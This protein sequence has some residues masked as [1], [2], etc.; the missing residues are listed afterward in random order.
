MSN[1]VHISVRDRNTADF[2]ESILN[3]APERHVDPVFI[4]DFDPFIP[5]LK[6]R[7]PYLLV[8]AYPN[9]I[10]DENE[11]AAIKAYA[12]KNRLDILCVGMQQ[13]WCKHNIP[14]TAF[15][16]LS[17]V[18]GAQCI[19]TDTF[20]GTVFS[21][22]YNKRFVAFI[23]E[24]N[25]NKLGGLLDQLQLKSRAVEEI[26]EFERIMDSSIDYEKV[27]SIIEHERQKASGYLDMI[28][29]PEG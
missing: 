24:S 21:A 28:T 27:N 25:R 29:Q 2:V 14:A 17:Y 26:E 13:R 16:L 5:Q 6:P 10:C 22:K 9:R 12:Q 19:V 4:S 23:R 7:K 8:Y 18:K 3:T 20:H 1:L 15:E 11:V